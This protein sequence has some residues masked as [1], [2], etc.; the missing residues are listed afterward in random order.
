MNEFSKSIVSNG[1]SGKCCEQFSLPFSITEFDRMIEAIDKGETTY[2]KDDGRITRSYKPPE[3]MQIREM[4]IPL[5]KTLIDP[6]ILHS[7]KSERV[8]FWMCIPDDE[9]IT[10]KD[11]D[12]LSV[13]NWQLHEW[14]HLIDGELYSDVYTCKNFDTEKRICKIYDDRPQMCRVFG[15]GCT[16]ENCGFEINRVVMEKECKDKL[17]T[18]HPEWQEGD[19]DCIK[20]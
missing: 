16:Y 6:Q 7:T 2:I 20:A 8:K 11:F 5:G 19:E 9:P 17:R 12:R 13:L 18:E 10:Q 3:L 14:I 4:I 15:R 1:C